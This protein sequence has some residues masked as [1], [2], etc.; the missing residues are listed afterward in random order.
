MAPGQV[1]VWFTLAHS[2]RVRNDSRFFT[3]NSTLF[4]VQDMKAY[5][6]M[7]GNAAYSLCLHQIEAINKPGASVAS[8]PL[9]VP[10]SA[11]NGERGGGGRTGVGILE[12]KKIFL[13]P[14]GNEP[15]DF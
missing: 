6:V 13:K 8:S 1:P 5:V 11:R 10:P 4:P 15:R 12:K 7:A 3:N 2:Q 9:M 14:F